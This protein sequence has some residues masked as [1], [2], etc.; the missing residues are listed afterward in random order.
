MYLTLGGL[1]FAVVWCIE[2]R[3][4]ELG[5]WAMS[6]TQ[7]VRGHGRGSRGQSLTEFA[8]VLPLF[9]I[10]LFGI[11]DIGRLYN[12]W[13]TLQHALR[14]AG[15][16]A[17]TGRSMTGSTREASIITV[18]QQASG[19]ILTDVQITSQSGGSGSA[20][21]AGD[22]V[23]ISVAYDLKLITPIIGQFF[24]NGVYRINASTT[25]KNEPFTSS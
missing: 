6:R 12:T 25:F 4:L 9:F 8:L 10:L 15:R 18:A 2:L 14:E 23:T 20:G 7:R 19:G 16:F 24:S 17:V 11:L 3:C 21:T 5:F 13:L 22:T 1:Q